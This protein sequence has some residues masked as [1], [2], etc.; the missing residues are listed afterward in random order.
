M[1]IS[2]QVDS[3]EELLQLLKND[4]VLAFDRIYNNYWKALYHAAYS[5]VNDEEVAKDIVQNVFIDIWQKRSKF[6]I[7]TSLKQYLHGAVKMKVLHHYRSENIKQ[8]V[9]DNAL[10]R[11]SWLMHSHYNLSSYFDLERIISEE[12]NEMPQNMKTSFLLRNDSYSVKQI[13][14][15][16]NL[17]EQT[18]S[19]NITEAIKRLKKRI[20]T[21]YPERYVGCFSLIALLFTQN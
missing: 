3:E 10:E 9:L 4:N 8:Q 2:N 13:A 7:T 15:S 16:L 14:G 11:I 6:E 1:Q 5:R 20:K 12:V 21:E 19:N 18:V 17:A